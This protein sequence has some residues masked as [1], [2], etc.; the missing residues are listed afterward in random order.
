MY[1]LSD[2]RAII[3]EGGWKT[4]IRSLGPDQLQDLSRKQRANG[5]GDI[6]FKK[7]ISYNHQGNNMPVKEI[8]FLGIDDVKEI[9]D[10]I[11]E[12]AKSN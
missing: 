11:R 1:V 12:V 8:G 7:E 5:S 4:N 2:K 9:E 3:F 6:V 10:K